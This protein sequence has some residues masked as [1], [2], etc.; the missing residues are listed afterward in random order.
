MTDRA[1]LAAVYRAGEQALAQTNGRLDALLERTLGGLTGDSDNGALDSALRD[2]GAAAAGLDDLDRA[3]TRR[4]AIGRLQDLEVSGAAQLV[5][6]A[7]RTIVVAK[8]ESGHGSVIAL[9]SPEPWPEAVAGAD[10]LDELYSTNRAF[11]VLDRSAA[12]AVA[13]WTM[14]TH[15]HDAADISPVLGITSPTKRCGKSTL[16]QVLGGLVPRPLPSSNLTAAALFRAVE[17][18]RPTL[19]VDE[20]DT[21]LGLRD[22]LRGVLNAG[23][24]RALAVVVRTVGDEHEVRTFS[25]WCPK[26]IALIGNLP[27]TL[28]DRSI[29]IRMRRRTSGER[30]TRLRQDRLAGELEPLRRKAARWAR[31]HMETLRRA[32][33]DTPAELSDRAAD[34]WRPLLAIADVAGGIWPTEARQAAVA[35]SG[36]GGDQDPA[37]V[38]LADTW[39]LFAERGEER[40]SSAAILQHLHSMT[41]RPWPEWSRGRPMTARAVAKLLHRFGIEPD[42]WRDGA[43]TVRGYRRGQLSDAWGR[44]AAF[45]GKEPATSATSATRNSSNDLAVAGVAGVALSF[46]LLGD[47][48]RQDAGPG[49]E[50][51]PPEYFTQEPPAAVP[52]VAP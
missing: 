31:D 6:A 23:H 26:A 18:F 7:L 21:F 22:E 20:A 34:N 47:A 5:D 9:R 27:D 46:P 32:D 11:V 4:A 38:L 40:L 25:T 52:E 51:V 35:L 2:F 49:L 44:Y 29:G 33:P 39:A 12:V 13:L 50:P 24:L 14:H 15:A 43:E 30:I 16:E 8:V 36:E 19:L 3:L 28:T 10:L 45:G 17:A 1:T 37:V 48:S 42:K 41:E